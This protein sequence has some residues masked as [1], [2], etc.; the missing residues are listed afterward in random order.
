MCPS[1]V[2]GWCLC[3]GEVGVSGAVKGGELHQASLPVQECTPQAISA[4]RSWIML[5]YYCSSIH[6]TLACK[7]RAPKACNP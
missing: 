6:A 5:H 4:S 7:H 3:R 2:G 1:Q